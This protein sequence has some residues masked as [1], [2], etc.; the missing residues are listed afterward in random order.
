[1]NSKNLNQK[2]IL[3]SK[4]FT[5]LYKIEQKNVICY[6]KV[7]ICVPVI[8]LCGGHL[9]IMTN[10]RFPHYEVSFWDWQ[11]FSTKGKEG[12]KRKWI[13][14]KRKGN[15]KKVKEKEKR[16]KKKKKEKRKKKKKKEERKE[17]RRGKCQA[18]KGNSVK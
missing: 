17:R 14:S 13:C 1:M 4:F 11:V 8:V 5:Y 12:D 15:K 16:K 9:R 10:S 7:S 6:H 2:F 18:I 3:T